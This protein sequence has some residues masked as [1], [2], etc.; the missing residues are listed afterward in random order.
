ME[1]LDIWQTALL[2]MGQYG[3][4][5]SFSAAQRADLLLAKGDARGFSVLVKVLNAIEHLESRK[6]RE[7]V[8]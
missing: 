2:L 1:Q 5:A 4:G 3:E 8:N 7:T 6:P